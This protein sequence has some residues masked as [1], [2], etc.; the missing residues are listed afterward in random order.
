MIPKAQEMFMTVDTYNLVNK[1]DNLILARNHTLG[2]KE[3]KF[4]SK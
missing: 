2:L 4:C 1:N 3:V